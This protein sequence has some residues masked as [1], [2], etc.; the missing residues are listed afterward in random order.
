MNKL[1]FK[2]TLIIF[3]VVLL[4]VT[5][6]VFSYISYG[7]QKIEL[8]QNINQKLRSQTYS[9]AELLQT[10]I[11]NFINGVHK[12]AQHYYDKIEVDDYVEQTQ[13]FADALDINGTVIAFKT[14]DVYWNDTSPS[15]PNHKYVGHAKELSWF[16]QGQKA[17]STTVSSPYIN[18]GNNIIWLGVV[19]KTKWGSISA[20]PQLAFIKKIISANALKETQELVIDDS[21]II[22][23]SSSDEYKLGKDLNKKEWFSTVSKNIRKNKQASGEFSYKNRT[24]M[25]FSQHIKLADKTWYYITTID[26]SVA[27]TRLSEIIKQ[28]VIFCLVAIV[29]SALVLL[30]L[31]RI[32]YSPIL[33]LKEM[34]QDLAQGEGNLTKRLEVKS[35]DD[36]G[37]IAS[38]VNIF[39]EKI[40]TLIKNSKNTSEQNANVAKE[41]SEASVSTGKRTGDEIKIIDK[42]V[43]IGQKAVEKIAYSVEV[44]EQNSKDLSSAVEN[45]NTIQ[46]EMDKLDE[47]LTKASEQSAQLSQKLAKTSQNTQEV[48]EVL[49]MINDISDQTN[50][51]ALNAAIEAARAGEHGRG[52]A[53]VADEVRKLAERTQK[54]LSEINTTMDVVV[55]SVDD[56]STDMS[57]EETSKVSHDLKQIVI[58]NAEIIK[59][60]IDTNVKNAKEYQEVLHSSNAVIEQI[61]KIEKIANTNAQSVKKVASASEDLSKMTSQLDNEL[62]KFKV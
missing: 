60:S 30:F 25:Y 38:N 6:S 59:K 53:V 15:Y 37:I 56:V 4:T 8:T 27:F 12:L 3:S 45:L 58:N 40:Q 42:T 13:V 11:V 39:I 22:I 57:L 24:Y 21:S 20:H 55:Q 31:L 36:L 54:S 43:G 29:L 51:L 33:E 23:G 9:Q 48:K 49:S 35:S 28:S 19:E 52:F 61:Q 18:P 50:L 26:K 16:Q 17:K 2:Q 7:S 10:R 44:A 47:L 62:S 34:V 41:L 1:G 32:I 46:S 14:G 5:I